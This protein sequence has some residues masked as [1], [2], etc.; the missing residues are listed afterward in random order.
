MQTLGC[1]LWLTA[2]PRQTK[3]FGTRQPLKDV[4]MAFLPSGHSPP[5]EKLG[6]LCEEMGG[7]VRRRGRVR[8][9][10]EEDSGE[11]I[12]ELLDDMMLQQSA[13]RQME[14]QKSK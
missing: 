6:R 9:E 7:E 12:S 5:D 2:V 14:R 11:F 4:L 8:E 3:G 1:L 13:E 10:E